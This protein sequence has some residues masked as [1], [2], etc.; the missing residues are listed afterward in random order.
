MLKSPSGGFSKYLT[1]IPEN[2]L[3]EGNTYTIEC[4]TIINGDI[5]GNSVSLKTFELMTGLFTVNAKKGFATNET[6]SFTIS[7]FSLNSEI[8]S[9]SY[10]L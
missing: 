7:H 3:K 1:S 6:F 5:I 4:S 2:T 10:Q 8:R 9:N